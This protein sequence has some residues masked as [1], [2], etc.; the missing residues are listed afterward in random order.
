M[1][2][3]PAVL[4]SMLLAAQAPAPQLTLPEILDRVAEEAEV[5][6]QNAPKALTQET[7]EQR[8]LVPPSRFQPRVGQAA[9]VAPKP[10]L[11]VREIVSEYSVGTLK[12]S[13]SRDLLEF[14]QVVS[15]D[16]RK[17]Q[18]AEHARHALSLGIQ[19]P[20]DR[21]RKRMLE[22]FA[23]H[24]LVD[25]ATDYGLILLAFTKRGLANMQLK[26]AGEARV[27]AENALVLSWRQTSA[28]G[29]ELEFFGNQAVRRPLQG[30]LYVRKSDGLPLRVQA[31]A[32][33]PDTN[34]MIRD[35]A[36]VD[37]ALST[38]GFLMP[39]SVVHRHLVDGRLRIENL[40]RYE[41]FK[42]FST[43]AEIKFSEV[44][45]TPPP[46]PEPPKK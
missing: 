8:A 18:S 32:E 43:D 20:D 13:D 14:R 34:R 28:A 23:K 33:H 29:G 44:P 24:G 7:L 36:A 25:V 17:V 21:V 37:Y 41:P 1:S 3:V 16:G 4:L 15:V 35:E 6:E 30:T 40:Y 26:L 38:H 22:D 2:L 19:S 31:W 12:E 5:L 11:V 9:T 10:R 45:D 42:L 46:P 27:G 39:A